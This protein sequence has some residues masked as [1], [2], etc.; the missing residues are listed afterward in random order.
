MNFRAALPVA[1]IERAAK[2]GAELI[3][4]DSVQSAKRFTA[5]TLRAKIELDPLD[6]PAE[7]RGV[8][9]VMLMVSK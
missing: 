7:L 5:T 2:S 9:C 6:R 1:L 8:T 4:C 3:V